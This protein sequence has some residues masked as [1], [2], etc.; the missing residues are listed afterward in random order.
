MPRK[1]LLTFFFICISSQLHAQQSDYRFKTGD[2]I[3]M[4]VYNSPELTDEFRIYADGNLR[5][6]L[7]GR[8]HAVNMTE[9]ELFET[10]E[11]RISVF[12]KNP[13]LTIIPKFQVSVLGYVRSPG[14]FT[15][16][17]TERIV[18][19]IAEA[20]GFSPEAS[21][22]IEVYR[23]DEKTDI[24]KH[25]ILESQSPIAYVQPGD[26]IIAK[27]KL[28]TKSDFSVILSTVTAV[29]LTIYY[30]TRD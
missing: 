8:V 6:P 23:N 25:N 10:L 29:A 11:E 18:E 30:T 22:K 28:F 21:G 3:Q 24:G 26:V 1:I 13:H 12:I 9:S 14:V 16:T 2:Y 7:I 17:G 20:G 15:I 27:R 19:L 4:Y 5:L